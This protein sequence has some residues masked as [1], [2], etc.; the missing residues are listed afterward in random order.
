MSAEHGSYVKRSDPVS[1]HNLRVKASQIKHTPKYQQ[2]RGQSKD[3]ESS[4]GRET[5]E[6]S[7]F[8]RESEVQGAWRQAREDRLQESKL[9]DARSAKVSDRERSPESIIS[10]RSNNA[11]SHAPERGDVS[12]DIKKLDAELQNSQI[13]QDWSDA[14]HQFERRKAAKRAGVAVESLSKKVL[15][16]KATQGRSR[17][18]REWSGEGT[19]RRDLTPAQSEWVAKKQLQEDV[20]WNEGGTWLKNQVASGDSAPSSIMH[21]HHHPDKGQVAAKEEMGFDI[22]VPK[23]YRDCKHVTQARCPEEQSAWDSVRGRPRAQYY[24]GRQLTQDVEFP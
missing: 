10:P 19:K 6:V 13:S 22:N 9:K 11:N 7:F 8:N 3:W 24:A 15:D 20:L 16:V 21:K 12:Q 4:G 1:D 17:H 14:Q 23:A 2:N 18:D 5:Q